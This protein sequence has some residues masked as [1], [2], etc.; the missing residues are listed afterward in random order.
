[1]AFG[2]INRGVL[3]NQLKSKFIVIEIFLSEAIHTVMTIQTCGAKGLNMRLHKCSINL[4]VT[5]L[6]DGRIEFCDVDG[7]AIATDKRFTIDVLLVAV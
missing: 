3:S 6:A 1:M 2:A 7:M 5:G 4:T